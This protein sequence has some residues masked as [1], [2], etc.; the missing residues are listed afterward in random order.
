MNVQHRIFH[1]LPVADFPHSAIRIPHFTR[2]RRRMLQMTDLWEF[3]KQF[4]ELGNQSMHCD[5]GESWFHLQCVSLPEALSQGVVQTRGAS[6][7]MVT[8]PYVK[9][10]IIAPYQHSWRIFLATGC[11]CTLLQALLHTLLQ[12]M[13]LTA[14]RHT[15]ATAEC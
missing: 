11:A 6:S 12:A 2:T 14:G 7:K 8:V 15:M 1:L 9:N 3:R 13:H 10:V 4:K 5:S